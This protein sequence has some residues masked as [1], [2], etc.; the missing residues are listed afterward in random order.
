MKF[1]L[2]SLLALGPSLVLGQTPVAPVQPAKTVTKVTE[3]ELAQRL[4][5]TEMRDLQKKSKS[6]D[7]SDPSEGSRPKNLLDRSTILCFGGMATLVPKG[8]VLHIPASIADRIGMQDGAKIVTWREFQIANRGWIV[9]QE[10]TM[11]QAEGKEPLAANVANRL[12]KEINMV[13]AT[14]QGGP[15]SMLKPLETHSESSQ[16]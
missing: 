2:S 9:T 16:P 13:V 4:L 12:G 10:V 5:Q 14:Y 1:L 3:Q 7:S 11:A 6:A 8:A 15:I